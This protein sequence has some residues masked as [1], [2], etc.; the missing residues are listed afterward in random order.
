M[1]SASQDTV[2][3]DV[4]NL[5]PELASE[6]LKNND[7]NRSVRQTKVQQYAT[8]IVA[9]RW[10][11]NGEPLIVSKNGLLNDGQHRAYAVIDSNSPISTL[12]VFGVDRDSR[13]TVDQGGARGAS[14][15]AQMEGVLNAASATSIARMVMAYERTDG[16]HLSKTKEVT[17]A[18]IMARIASDP[19]IGDAAH[20]AVSTARHASKFAAGT[21]LGFCF[22]VLTRIHRGEAER[23][24][25]QVCIGEGLR[26]GDPAHTVREKLLDEGKSRDRKASIIFR[27][28]NFNRRGRKVQ[29]NGLKST[30]P[31]PALI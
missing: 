13:T 22:Y 10:V 29:P 1:V 26:R 25:E 11:F 2:L 24:L 23:Y 21:V 20:F 18:E 5:T 31:F 17:N 16:Q 3:T 6:L 27:G 9:G 30:L 15:Y 4:V 7:R 8:D 19:K 28:W 14:D 12:I